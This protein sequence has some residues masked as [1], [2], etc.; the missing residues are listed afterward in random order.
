MCYQPGGLH[1]VQVVSMVRPG[2]SVTRR[3]KILPASAAPRREPLS[4]GLEPATWEKGDPT[5]L[6]PENS[7]VLWG[8]RESSI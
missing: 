3:P 8:G 7:A 1:A 4:R 6:F 2:C 5:A